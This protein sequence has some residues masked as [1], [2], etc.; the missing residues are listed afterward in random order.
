[1]GSGRPTS[2]S[3]PTAFCFRSLARQQAMRLEHLGDLVADPHQRVQRRHRLL[4]HHRDVAAAQAEPL[5]LVEG[6]EVLS[7]KQN[8]AGFADDVVGQQSH[9]GVGAHRLSRTGFA[10]HAKDLAGGEI[11]GNA[12][13][14]VGPVAA[15]RQRQLQVA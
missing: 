15:G 8:L 11:E 10:D 2:R 7:L 1:M 9:Q 4:E 14:G 12:I 13:H 3:R 5:V 6:Q